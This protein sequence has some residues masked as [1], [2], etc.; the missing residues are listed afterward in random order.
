MN[1]SSYLVFD[2]ETTGLEPDQ[3]RIIQVGLCEVVDGSVARRASWLVNQEV[4]VPPDATRIHGI[5][6]QALRKDGVPPDKSLSVLL[7]TLT[8]APACVGHNIH[9]FDVQFLRSECHRLEM[10]L[11][12]S[13]EYVDTAALFKGWRMGMPKSPHETH[14]R[15]ADRVLSQRVYGLKYSVAACMQHLQINNEGLG[16]HDAGADTFCTHL[17]FEALKRSL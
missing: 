14:E 4:D 5:T 10:P 8:T 9:R 16:L 7:K 15:Y 2:F 6:T 13:E 12:N 1:T 3:D 17:I 11:P